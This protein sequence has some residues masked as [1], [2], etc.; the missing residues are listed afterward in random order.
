[1]VLKQTA[2]QVR[3]DRL[4]NRATVHYGFA[5]LAARRRY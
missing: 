1:M 2:G 3:L 4:N 5:V